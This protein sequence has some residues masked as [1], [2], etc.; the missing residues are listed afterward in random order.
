MDFLERKMIEIIQLNTDPLKDD[1]NHDNDEVR[2]VAILE[3]ASENINPD[4]V[5]K[6]VEKK[7]NSNNLMDIKEMRLNA[8]DIVNLAMKK[9]DK[10]S[11]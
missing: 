11:I 5:N 6:F 1:G 4:D 2:N 10:A 3:K 9:Y 8:N 7:I